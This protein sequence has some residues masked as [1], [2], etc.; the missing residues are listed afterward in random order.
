MIYSEPEIERI[1][2]V[3]FETARKR[4]NRLCSVEK[5]NVLVGPA[6]CCSPRHPTP[7]EPSFLESNGAL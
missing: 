3:G 5:S 6:R 4:S 7:F 1:A 2:R